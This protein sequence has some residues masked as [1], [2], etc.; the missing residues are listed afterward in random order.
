MKRRNFLSTVASSPLLNV[1]SF[2]QILTK[3]ADVDLGVKADS[4]KHSHRLFKYRLEDEKKE[5]SVQIH[6]DE[7]AW[8][9]TV[10]NQVENLG[11]PKNCVFDIQNTSLIYCAYFTDSEVQ[12][13]LYEIEPALTMV[14]VKQYE[15]HFSVANRE[16]DSIQDV[17][18]KIENIK[19][20]RRGDWAL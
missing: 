20:D 3:D 5:R 11:F 6:R 1:V 15:N 17:R 10:R 8:I 13:L 14:S 19:P 9:R 12:T 18:K 7:E 4:K 2:D 16:L